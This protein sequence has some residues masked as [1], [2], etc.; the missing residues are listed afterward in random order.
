L[1]DKARI[2]C[3]IFTNGDPQIRAQAIS[4]FVNDRV[5]VLLLSSLTSSSGLNL[6]MASQV[7]FLDCPGHSVSE[8]S[9]LEQ[10]AI[11]R[12]VR[13][14]Q[15]NAVKIL[16]F[17]GRGTMEMQMF[18]EVAAATKATTSATLEKDQR[19]KYVCDGY[20]QPLA[21]NGHLV[22]SLDK[23]EEALVIGASAHA[24][25]EK[26]DDGD[27]GHD[28]DDDVIEFGAVIGVE[29]RVRLEM[30]KAQ[31][32]GKIVVIDDD[33]NDDDMYDAKYDANKENKKVY[34]NSHVITP[35]PSSSMSHSSSSL[36]VPDIKP[37]LQKIKEERKR[38]RDEQDEFARQTEEKML[39]RM[40]KR[41]LN[42]EKGLNPNTVVIIID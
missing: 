40:E 13:M 7:I 3:E 17:V 12:V 6:Q 35:S 9:T 5:D 23:E 27:E 21:H 34:R 11:G 22:K 24:G 14:G 31:L 4:S 26:R 41:R 16:R 37:D 39:R 33:D 30:Q 28:C 2:P 25:K 42:A 15:Q 19:D 18:L 10:Q 29:E 8:G 20:A 32:E 38:L 36:S 1:R